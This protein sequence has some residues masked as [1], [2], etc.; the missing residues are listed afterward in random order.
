MK[1]EVVAI[2]KDLQKNKAATGKTPLNILKKLNFT[3]D[4]LTESVN[5]P[6]KW[7]IS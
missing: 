6:F 4:E 2:I 7:K 3:F 1:D 5:Y